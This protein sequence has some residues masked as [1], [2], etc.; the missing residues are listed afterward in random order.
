MDYAKIARELKIAKE[1]FASRDSRRDGEAHLAEPA[2]AMIRPARECPKCG[3][4]QW[5][6]TAETERWVCLLTR[7]AGIRLPRPSVRGSS[8]IGVHSREADVGGDSS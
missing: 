1:A 2:C 6:R 5:V 8:G 4:R 7:Y 3:S